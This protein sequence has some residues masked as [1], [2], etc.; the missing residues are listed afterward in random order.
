MTPGELALVRATWRKVIPVRDLAA[1]LFYGKL[2]SLDPKIRELFKGDM[3][4][5]GRNLNAMISVAV[6]GL[7]RPDKILPAVRQLGRRHVA[8]G[9]QERHYA[10]FGSALL[11]ALEKCLLEEFTP[12]ARAAWTAA[13]A[14]L[15]GAMQEA[16]YAP[17]AS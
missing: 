15:A 12:E 11:W 13:Y 17:S 2:F 8:Y 10:L 3:K 16:A 1:D 5:Q 14:L 6:S 7:A 9:V 4:E